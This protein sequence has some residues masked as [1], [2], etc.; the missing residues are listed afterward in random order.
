MEAATTFSKPWLESKSSTR[1]LL[2][3]ETKIRTEE[4]WFWPIQT[5]QGLSLLTSFAELSQ[6][7]QLSDVPGVS[8]SVFKEVESI[9]RWLA[10][11][12]VRLHNAE[13]IQD[14]LAEFPDLIEVLLRAVRAVKKYLPGA[15]LI[16]KVYQDP[17]IEDRYLALYVR[18]PQYDEK[19]MERIEAAESEY[20]EFLADSKGWLQLT[21]DFGEPEVR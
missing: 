7:L 19:V 4:T 16:L 10:E 1:E 11:E 2:P 5:P 13:K 12:E 8:T 14:Y 18:L 15:Q 6:A 17:E 20:I 9:I 3:E 21:T